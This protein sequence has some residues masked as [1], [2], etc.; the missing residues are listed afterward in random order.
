MRGFSERSLILAELRPEGTVCAGFI[1][2]TID[3]WVL[4]CSMTVQSWWLEMSIWV[5]LC[6]KEFI[7]SCMSMC[8]RWCLSSDS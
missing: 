8:L 3:I 1:L 6:C 7:Y 5:V 4:T 2:L